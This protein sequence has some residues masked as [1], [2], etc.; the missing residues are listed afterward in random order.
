MEKNLSKY[1]QL[2]SISQFFDLF[3]IRHLNFN[4][5]I[6]LIF[7]IFTFISYA[8]FSAFFIYHQTKEVRSNMIHEGVTLSKLLAYSSRLAVFA[9][10]PAMLKGPLDG[11]ME[12]SEVILIQVFNNEGK[13]VA[14]RVCNDYISF[15]KPSSLFVNT[16]Y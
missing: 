3:K 15:K 14:G 5:K 11:V 6:F 7:I 9:E 13:E 4:L 16:E 10:N 1:W 2:K 8:T 12:H